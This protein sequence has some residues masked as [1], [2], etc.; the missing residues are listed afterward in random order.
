MFK[1]ILVLG[2]AKVV[3]VVAI[4]KLPELAPVR[5]SFLHHAKTAIVERNNH[6]GSR[7]GV[8]DNVA[9]RDIAALRRTAKDGWHTNQLG[10]AAFVAGRVA[11]PLGKK[12]LTAGVSAINEASAKLMK[13]LSDAFGGTLQPVAA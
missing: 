11:A 2:T 4:A 13:D 12:A 6:E 9:L 7:D 3:A 5:R 10:R 8:L 1:A